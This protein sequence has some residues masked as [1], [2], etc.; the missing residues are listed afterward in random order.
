M[1]V[2]A[3]G[4]GEGDV[5]VAIPFK[6]PVGSKRRLSG[7]LDEA[8]RARLSLA[9]LDGVLEAALSA[10]AVAR[11]LVMLPAAVLPPEQRDPR[12]AFVIEMPEHGASRVDG[13]GVDGLN[14]A[15][16]QAQLAAEDGGATSLL[17]LPAD[18]P[19][20]AA[21]DVEALVAASGSSAV[22]ISPD[23][24]SEGTNALLLSPPSALVPSFGVASFERHRQLAARAGREVAVVRRWGLALDLDTPADVLRLF[25]LGQECRAIRLLRDLDVTSRLGPLTDAQPAPFGA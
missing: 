14:R 12:L 13:S 8:E 5:W 23:R 1:T 2:P 11:V 7:L 17:V 21:D 22:V 24:A 19:L 16:V 6:G 15:L 25:A 18:L 3:N 10:T 4:T 20:I 9:M